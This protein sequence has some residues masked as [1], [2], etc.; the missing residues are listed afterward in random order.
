M[1]N[2]Q[3]ISTTELDHVTGG[4]DLADAA[5]GA[6]N[7]VSNPFSAAWRFGTGMGGALRQGHGFGDSFAN[8][9]VQA[10]DTMRA[11]NLANIPANRR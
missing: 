11:P 8:G 10:A 2:F 1:S 4:G 3:T 6:L 7:I 5:A 9:V